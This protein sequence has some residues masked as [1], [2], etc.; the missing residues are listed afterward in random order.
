MGKTCSPVLKAP[1]GGYWSTPCFMIFSPTPVIVYRHSRNNVLQSI[2]AM[3]VIVDWFI[4]PII[5][6]TLTELSAC[7][8][9]HSAGKSSVVCSA[10]SPA[11]SKW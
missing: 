5:V 8:D 2:S 7:S 9:Y 11:V 4:T 1:T 3:N 6:G 10:L